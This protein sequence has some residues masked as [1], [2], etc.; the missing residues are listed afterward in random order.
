MNQTA[1]FEQVYELINSE[2]TVLALVEES[3]NNG[4]LYLQGLCLKGNRKI[5]TKVTDS[6]LR[7]YLLG[8]ITLRELFALRGDEAYLL[9]TGDAFEEV[10]IEDEQSSKIMDTLKCGDEFYPAISASMRASEAVDEILARLQSEWVRG[11]AEV[12]DGRMTE[13]KYLQS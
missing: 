8:R 12:Y 6:A 11:V 13:S 9:S 1:K 10:Y 7:L 4:H 2:G 3:A 5:Y